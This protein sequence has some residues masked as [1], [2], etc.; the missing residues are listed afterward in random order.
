MDM[1]PVT[2][3]LWFETRMLLRFIAAKTNERI[4]QV[5]HRLAVAEW[6]RLSESEKPHDS[7]DGERRK[8]HINV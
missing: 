5:V 6:S 8:H 2:V 4:V 1:K 7:T 3:K